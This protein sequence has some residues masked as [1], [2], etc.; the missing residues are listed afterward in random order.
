M[1]VK[2][3]LNLEDD[4]VRAVEEWGQAQRPQQNFS[5]ALRTLVWRALQMEALKE[6]KNYGKAWRELRQAE[7]TK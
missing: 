5:Q 7:R 2:K 6:P 1:Y 3:N 4:L